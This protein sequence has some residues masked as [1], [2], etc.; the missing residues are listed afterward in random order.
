[1]FIR[2]DLNA[3]H[4]SYH[5]G[6]LESVMTSNLKP[7]KVSDT[8]TK[9]VSDETTENKF[10]SPFTSLEEN[11]DENDTVEDNVD[12]GD[13]E[14]GSKIFK[15]SF[16]EIGKIIEDHIVKYSTSTPEATFATSREDDASKCTESQR[17]VP[18]KNKPTETPKKNTGIEDKPSTH[19]TN[20]ENRKPPHNTSENNT[21]DEEKPRAENESNDRKNKVLMFLS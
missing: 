12:S 18:A 21:R 13:V 11:I 15:E 7:E 9:P 20:A 8:T 3:A 17:V 16:H 1:M 10:N 4:V 19:E 14:A 6:E 2:Q 5:V